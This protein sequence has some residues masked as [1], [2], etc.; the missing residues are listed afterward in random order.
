[1]LIIVENV[2]DYDVRRS[3]DTGIVDVALQQ[4]HNSSFNRL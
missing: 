3:V 2:A 1:M 4:L